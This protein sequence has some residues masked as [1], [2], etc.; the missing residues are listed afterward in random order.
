MQA[1]TVSRA[2]I[3]AGLLLGIGLPAM[4][5]IT[6]TLKDVTF[7]NGNK[8]SGSFTTNDAVT[9]VDSFAISITGAAANAEF[10][11]ALMVNAYLPNTIGM[12]SAD[13]STYVDL[14]LAAP[15]TSAGGTVDIT[16]GYDCPSGL[17]CGVLLLGQPEVIG[18]TA[19]S[20]PASTPLP[21]PSPIAFLA[22]ASILIGPAL[23]RRMVSAR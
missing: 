17:R 15:L 14:Y 8:V 19:T 16:G 3:A 22:G 2:I 20:N 1:K 13:W 6:W 23:R 18:L 9:A 12:A 4:A 11:P 10:T 7:D 5:D 21:E